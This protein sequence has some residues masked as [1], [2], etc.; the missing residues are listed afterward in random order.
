MKNVRKYGL[1]CAVVLALI[2]FILLLATPALIASSEY[3]VLTVK[4]TAAIFGANGGSPIGVALAAWILLLI[5]LLCGICLAVLPF[6]KSV[7]LSKNAFALL[8]C[9]VA[10]VFLVVGILVFCIAADKEPFWIGGGWGTAGILLILAAF[11]AGLDSVLTL[12][13]K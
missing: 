12:A 13:R 9:L 10:V 8:G 7:K 11:G 2:A 1:Y 5:G 3:L 6:I 4:G